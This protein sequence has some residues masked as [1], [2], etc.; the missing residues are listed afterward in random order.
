[1]PCS[2]C[3]DSNGVAR[4]WVWVDSYTG[5]TAGPGDRPAIIMLGG[6]GGERRSQ[7]SDAD[8]ENL[9]VVLSATRASGSVILCRP[10]FPQLLE[11][12]RRLRPGERRLVWEVCASRTVD[13]ASLPAGRR[14]T[15]E[16][17]LRALESTVRELD[18][19]RVRVPRVIQ[20]W[21]FPTRQERRRILARGRGA[22]RDEQRWRN[23]EIV[24]RLAAGESARAISIEYGLSASRLR[25]IASETAR[26]TAPG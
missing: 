7:P 6:G 1:M 12:L 21:R 16:A 11:A 26:R 17:A 2:R 18:G 10:S 4:G 25:R 19:G 22:N 8:E 13:E 5:V 20:D 15:L 9:R 3:R 23:E 14:A 24:S